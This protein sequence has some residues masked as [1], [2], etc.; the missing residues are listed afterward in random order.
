MK[1][2]NCCTFR[3]GFTLIELLVV[4]AIIAILAGM[5]LPA[6][7]KAKAK[8]HAIK[9]AGN[10]KQI[11]LANYMY[12]SDEGKAVHY[13]NWPDLWMNLLRK[14]Y[15]AID[16]VRLCPTAPEKTVQQVA[17]DHSAGKDWGA[18]NRPWVI[19]GDAK[20][21]YQGGYGLNGW[22]YSNSQFYKDT[23]AD[24]ARYFANDA[25]MPSP[26][27]TPFFADSAWVDSWP[28]ETDRPASNLS[29]GD[30][31]DGLQRFT[32]P[33]HAASLK[34]AM[35]SFNPK[36]QLPG[37]INISFGDN[38]VEMVRLEKLWQLYWTATWV[39]PDKRPGT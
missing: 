11:G 30:S 14:R 28:H 37:A 13:D 18:V 4:I 23:A 2:P 36:N 19:Y 27:M 22:L 24:K 16:Q 26:S 31:G 3:R 5:L 39:V 35:A 25:S 38:H 12:F 10:L 15:N 1:R 32:I 17:K 29:T 9:C 6:L 34:A 33:R 7:A 20:N 8:A 21:Y